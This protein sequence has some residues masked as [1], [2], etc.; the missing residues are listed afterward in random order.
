MNRNTP[1]RFLLSGGAGYIGSVTAAVLIEAGHT[2]TVIDNLVTG[3][4]EA[5]HPAARFVEGNISNRDAIAEACSGGIDV[6]MHFAAFIEVGESVRNPSKYYQNN[7]IGTMQF[8]DNLRVMGIERFVFSSSAA[9]Y[10]ESKEI[11]LTEN[12][13][14]KPVSP[15]GLTK[16]MAEK[17]L[18]DYAAA[19]QFRSTSLRYF[20]ASGAYDRY[21]EDHRPESHLI[22]RVLDVAR[23]G[24]P[25]QVFGDDYDT[26]DGSCIRDYIHVRDIASA[27]VRA[28]EYLMKDGKMDCFNLGSNIGRTVLEV[29]KTAEKVTGKRIPYEIAGRRP[30][31]SAI[32][33]ASSEKAWHVLGWGHNLEPLEAI[34][35]SAWE[36][37][38]NHLDGY[39]SS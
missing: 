22:P 12:A 25:L 30:G 20:N 15:Y 24:I 4:R 34:I 8:I 11:P 5:V 23:T 29:I 2:V 26:R 17:M 39:E 1:L 14:L 7:V 16:L 33:V 6:V 19:Y 37:Y 10:G 21:G 38:L 9:V 28:A 36:W 3:H 18:C 35:S 13:P 27:H 32:L 31:D